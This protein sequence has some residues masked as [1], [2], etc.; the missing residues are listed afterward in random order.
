MCSRM[1]N[2]AL[3]PSCVPGR[4]LLVTL[5][6]TPKATS[7]EMLVVTEQQ[8]ISEKEVYGQNVTGRVRVPLAL[9]VACS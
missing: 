2:T 1:H 8:E 9:F 7:T 6:F 4:Y 5:M 3:F